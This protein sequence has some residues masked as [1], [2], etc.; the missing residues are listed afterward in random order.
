M[1][2]IVLYNGEINNFLSIKEFGPELSIPLSRIYNNL[3]KTGQ[4]PDA[5]KVEFGLPLKKT[6]CPKNEDVLRML[7]NS[8]IFER[9]IMT[10]LLEYLKD[11][12][13]WNQ[14]GGQKG[15]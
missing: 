2:T 9:F 14:Y 6:T 8:K 7:S 3:V 5:W 11:H 10:W 12:I 13:D 4:W 15:N 1:L